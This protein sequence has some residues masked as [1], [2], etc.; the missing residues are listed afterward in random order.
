MRVFCGLLLMAVGSVAIAAF[1]LTAARQTGG[2]HPLFDLSSPE[3]S[4]F[5]SD[6]FTV[7]DDE[8]NTARRVN[9]P[10]PEDCTAEASQCEDVAVLNQLDGFNLVARISVPFDGDIDPASVTSD[11]VFLVSLGDAL[12]RHELAHD[13]DRYYRRALLTATGNARRA[14]SQM[15]VRA[16]RRPRAGWYTGDPIE[17]YRGGGL[18]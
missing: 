6:R 18:F 1:N 12:A 4:P 17:D 5:P 7:A 9:L 10:V 14:E 15:S 3:R 13:S 11:T 8:Q 16:G 2:V